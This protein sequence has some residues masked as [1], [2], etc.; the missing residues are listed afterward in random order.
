LGDPL[1]ED[2][3]SISRFVSAEAKSFAFSGQRDSFALVRLRVS[4]TTLRANHTDRRPVLNPDTMLVADFSQHL[5]GFSVR[6]CQFDL[7]R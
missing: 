3:F 5:L 7:K 6:D 4:T 1:D 2:P